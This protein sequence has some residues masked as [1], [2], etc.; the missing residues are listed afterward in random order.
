MIRCLSHAAIGAL[1]V[2]LAACMDAPAPD[3]ERSDT[4][5]E[6]PLNVHWFYDRPSLITWCT[7]RKAIML[8][9]F[10]AK[11]V[12]C[13]VQHAQSCDVAAPRNWRGDNRMIYSA[14]NHFSPRI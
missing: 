11:A 4:H 7:D 12:A 6:V 8:P 3:P 5:S 14:C 10:G 2:G 1:F 9:E 13:V